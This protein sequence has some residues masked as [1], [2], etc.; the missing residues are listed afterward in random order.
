MSSPLSLPRSRE[1]KGTLASSPGRLADALDLT[2]NFSKDLARTFVYA[3][4]MSDQDTRV[5]KYQG[6]Q[7]EMIQLASELSAETSFVEP[8][9]LKMEPPADFS[10]PSIA[11]SD[12][13]SV[14]LTSAAFNEYRAVP[15]RDDRQKV[16]SAFFGGVDMTT[17][18]PLD[19]TIK[20]MNRVM[21]DMEK[22]IK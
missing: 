22:L 21:D 15:N 9:I 3:S 14:K 7:Q 1:F 17:D 20:K 2:T 19:L 18:E 13:K 10:Y 4:M 5:S 12:G 6:M 8:E 16:M 11:L